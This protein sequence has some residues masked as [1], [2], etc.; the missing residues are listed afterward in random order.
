MK[1]EGEHKPFCFAGQRAPCA[2]YFPN[3]VLPCIC[4]AQGDAVSALS[5]VA[6]P[7]PLGGMP[8]PAGEAPDKPEPVEGRG[9]AAVSSA[10]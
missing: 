9:S 10:F 5:Q 6:V 3:N 8:V 7:A 2:G 4:G 1:G